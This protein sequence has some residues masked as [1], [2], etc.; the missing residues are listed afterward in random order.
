MRWLGTASR[1]EL[2]TRL[3]SVV[4]LARE[5]EPLEEPLLVTEPAENTEEEN[6]GNTNTVESWV[7]EPTQE[8]VVSPI[9][10]PIRLPQVPS[11]SEFVNRRKMKQN[12]SID[13]S[14]E[15]FDDKKPSKIMKLQ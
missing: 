7:D 11:F 13:K 3:S 10:S 12:R 9:I 2:M 14:S 15:G 4:S 1:D 6:D 5:Q 8:L